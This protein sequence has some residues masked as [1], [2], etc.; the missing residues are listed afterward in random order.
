[1]RERC[2]YICQISRP[3]FFQCY[4]VSGSEA[5]AVFVASSCAFWGKSG[6]K[7][8]RFTP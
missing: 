4:S 2:V 8:V 7:S 1:M 6:R 3:A 5:P